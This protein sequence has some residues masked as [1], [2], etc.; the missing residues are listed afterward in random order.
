MGPAFRGASYRRVMSN[1]RHGARAVERHCDVVVVGGSAAGLAAALQLGRQRRSVIVVDADEPRNAPAA[2][3]HGYL[4]RDGSPPSEL[5]DLGR[6]E[7][8]SYGGEV[9]AGRVTEVTRL[10]QTRFRAE[11]V[12]GHSVVARR[13]LA[14]T[15]L[16]DELPDIGGLANHWGEG[17]IHCPFC[18]GYEVRD[19]PIVQI[20]THP[21]GLR[22][23]VLWA[24]LTDRLTVV[25]HGD[26]EVDGPELDALR[27]R[28]LTS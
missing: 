19:R 18:H 14:A 9:L 5:I 12:G 23:T 24:Q 21:M 17:V 3:M 10:D 8:R 15:G 22:A 28:G 27:A 13:V 1:H 2:H 16:V 25:R 7:V 11:L 6:E 4:T 20:L 26:V